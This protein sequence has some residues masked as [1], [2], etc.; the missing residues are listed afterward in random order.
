MK[1]VFIAGNWK[2]NKTIAESIAWVAQ[3]KEQCASLQVKW[4]AV[5][6]V[7]CVPYT[8]LLTVKEEL[9]AASLPV[10]V[11]AQDVS[12]FGEGA[13]TGEVTGKMIKEAADWVVIG[14]SERRKYFGETDEIL[15]K[16]TEKA[17]S[18]GLKVIYCV[19]DGLA[20]VPD[21]VEV[22]AYEPVW[23]IGTG[24]TDSPQNANAVV[25]TIKSKTR[26]SI[27]MYGGSVTPENVATFVDKPAIDGVL[28]GGASLIAETYAHLIAA[29]VGNP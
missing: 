17:R 14:H 1:H 22:V 2:S 21:G 5:T 13:Y 7:V 9:R 26:A 8:V 24:K 16:K 11:A 18:A 15:K 23:A 25:S 28:P 6:V 4:D 10:A 19:P 27:V 3:L 12:E 29:A 20:P